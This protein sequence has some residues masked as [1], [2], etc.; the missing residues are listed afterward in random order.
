[1]NNIQIETIP[2]NQTNKVSYLLVNKATG[3]IAIID[4]VSNICNCLNKRAKNEDYELEWILLTNLPTEF[5]EL[6]KLQAEF[7]CVIASS[8]KIIQQLPR[9]LLAHCEQLEN[10]EVVMFGHLALEAVITGKSITYQ[11]DDHIFIYDEKSIDTKALEKLTTTGSNK[12]IHL[13][14]PNRD[15]FELNYELSPIELKCLVN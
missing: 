6:S 9:H 4:P 2:S 8:K 11:I 10:H 7:A 14:H 1:M 3:A 5:S 12:L 13:I 15:N